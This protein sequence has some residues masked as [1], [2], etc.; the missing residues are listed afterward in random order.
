[1]TTL[2]PDI[3]FVQRFFASLNEQQIDFCIMRNAHEVAAGDAHDVDM[4]I[5]ASRMQDAEDL[6]AQHASS[7]G[8]KLHLHTGSATD[9]SNIKCYHY[10]YLDAKTRRIF[11]VH[12]DVFPTFAWKGFELLSNSVL[13]QNI[14][15]DTIYHSIA[16]ENEAVCNLFV[17][18]L[19]NGKVKDKYKPLIHQTYTRNK[20]RVCELM[21]YFLSEQLT[22]TIYN[23]VIAQNWDAIDNM[24]AQITSNVKKRTKRNLVGYAKYLLSK[25]LHRRGLVVA[26][27]GTD[28]SGKSTIIAGIANVL[29]NT[30]SGNTLNYYHW[31]PSFIKPEKNLDVNSNTIS[32][33]QPHTAPPRNKLMSLLKLLVCTADYVLGYWLKIYW[34]AAKGHLVVFDRYY[35]DF[36]MD[37]LRY[38]LSIS[39]FWIRF[40]QFFIPRPDLTF[41]L[42]GDAKQIYERKKEISVEEIERQI[43]TMLSH[44]TKFAN[45]VIINVS[46]SIDNVLYDVSETILDVLHTRNKSS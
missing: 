36:Y 20:T 45:P 31:R 19:H 17:R 33:V 26:F 21:R 42:I 39:E 29:G 12:I 9:A 44:Q 40:F 37:K 6:L 46:Q 43:A 5:R 8:W 34:Q 1:M 2:P 28:G 30:F 15:C 32:N 13:L 11:I 24:R 4:C 7:L 35:Y 3:L 16:V 27:Q 38:R 14:N 23:H 41:L 10:Y 22:E 25:A 18:L